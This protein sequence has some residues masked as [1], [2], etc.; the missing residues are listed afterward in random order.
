MVRRPQHPSR[1]IYTFKRQILVW[2]P[3]IDAPE[4][5]VKMI[6]RQTGLPRKNIQVDRRIEMLVDKDFGVNDFL[7]YVSSDRHTRAVGN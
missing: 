7:I 3:L 6:S 4:K 1:V 2:C 5:P